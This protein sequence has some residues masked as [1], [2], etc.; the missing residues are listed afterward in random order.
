MNK[1]TLWIM[2]GLS[3]SGKSTITTQI[4]NENPNTIIVSSDFFHS[5]KLTIGEQRE[6]IKKKKSTI[7]QWTRN[8][9]IVV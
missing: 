9:E 4:A 7:K 2:C 3:S 8:M 1:P 6:H 5:S